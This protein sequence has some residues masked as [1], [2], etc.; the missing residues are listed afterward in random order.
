MQRDERHLVV[1]PL[2]AAERVEHAVAPQKIVRRRGQLV[3]IGAQL[4]FHGRTMIVQILRDDAVLHHPP[5]GDAGAA[6]RPCELAG[7]RKV[8]AQEHGRAHND[9][10]AAAREP[11]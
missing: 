5:E 3:A 4:Q 2:E 7:Q 8:G 10:H 1:Q 6:R 11:A 9:R